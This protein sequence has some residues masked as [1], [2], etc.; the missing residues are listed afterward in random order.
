MNK[1]TLEQAINEAQRFIKAAEAA[2]KRTHAD[3]LRDSQR[4]ALTKEDVYWSISKENASCKRASL[5]LS[6]ILADLRQGR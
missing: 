1:Q 3:W 2:Q 4:L 5:D 6:R